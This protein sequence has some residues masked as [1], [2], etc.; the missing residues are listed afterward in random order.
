LFKKPTI[1]FSDQSDRNR[2]G[3]SF[4]SGHMTNNTIIAVYCTLFY[5]RGG[6]LYWIVAAAVGYSR[7][8]L[9]AHWLSDILATLFLATG[10]ALLMLGLFEW[11]WRTLGRKWA[12]NIYARHWSL[13]GDL[14]R[15]VRRPDAPHESL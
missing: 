14:N 9:G 4:P 6:W 7:I 8:Y 12:P 5:R 13:I 2:S 15:R 1:R 10:E 11:I 3:P